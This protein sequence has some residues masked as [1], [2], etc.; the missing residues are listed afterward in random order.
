M[1]NSRQVW[2]WSAAILRRCALPVSVSSCLTAC[3][4][5]SPKPVNTDC[6]PGQRKGTSGRCTSSGSES[7]SG[8][9]DRYNSSSP[10]RSYRPGG[11]ESSYPETSDLPTSDLPDGS[12]LGSDSFGHRPGG[13]SGRFGQGDPSRS[14]S[15][16]PRTSGFGDDDFF[17][18]SS[19]RIPLNSPSF[20]SSPSNSFGNFESDFG[21]GRPSF[22]PGGQGS[23]PDRS[24]WVRPSNSFERPTPSFPRD[25]NSPLPSG[26]N[27]DLPR[28]TPEPGLSP[29]PTASWSPNVRP[30]FLGSPLLS[31]LAQLP[32]E[33]Q[34]SGDAPTNSV[35]GPP[36]VKLRLGLLESGELAV[37]AAWS[38]MEI[39]AIHYVYAAKPID[40]RAS[41]EPDGSL[42][43]DDIFFQVLVTFR[44]NNLSCRVGPVD[45][46]VGE[47]PFVPDCR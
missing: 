7:P 15:L 31:P 3:S 19:K 14:P 16:G 11:L 28:P 24:P 39:S 27:G 45:V 8:D 5:S 13:G 37:Q 12:D 36:H 20:S 35:K 46:G 9:D 10:R 25:S 42:Q 44:F 33:A 32:E 26:G 29:V 4:G 23:R 18:S 30:S 2:G 38:H 6:P 17:G 34:F 47:R 1:L 43:I 40:L 22:T 21:S 41:A